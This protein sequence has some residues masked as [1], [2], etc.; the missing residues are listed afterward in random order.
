M[1][2]TPR[3]LNERRVRKRNTPPGF[4]SFIKTNRKLYNRENDSGRILLLVSAKI[5]ERKKIY[6]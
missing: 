5:D 3:L 1:N 2:T 6:I 4:S